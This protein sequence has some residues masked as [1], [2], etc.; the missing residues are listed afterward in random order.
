MRRST[1]QRR[2]AIAVLTAAGFVLAALTGVG[3]VHADHGTFPTSAGIYRIPYSDGM[4]LIVSGDHHNHGGT[5][6][7]GNNRIDMVADAPP[8]TVVA[9]A[10]GVVMAIVD[11]HG[12]S[13][14]NGDGLDVNG[15]SGQVLFDGVTIHSDAA[16]HSCQDQIEPDVDGDGV[17]D[18]DEDL[19]GSGTFN[20]IPNSTVIGLCQDYNNYIWIEHP[21]GEWSKYTHMDT[22]TITGAPGNLSV[23]DTVLVGQALGIESDIGA[24]TGRHLHHE[25]AV[26]TD[27]T[28]D[29]PFNDGSFRQLDT[30]PG[31]GNAN[32][33][34]SGTVGFF[35]GGFIQGTNL[36]PTVCDIPG[37][38]YADNVTSP[39]NNAFT[40]NPCTNT[41]P[42]ADA[43]GPYAVDEGSTVQLDGTGSSDPENA[44]LSFSWSPATRL[45][46]GTIATPTYDALD[47][48]V[49]EIDLTVSDV[50]GDVTPALALTDTDTAV[51]TVL[52]VAPTVTAVGDSID[53]A[54]TATVSATFTDPGT[55]DTHTATID[56]ADGTPAEPVT[57]GELEAGV[58]HVYGDNGDFDV[59]VTV[60]DDDGGSGDD[61]A[62]VSVANLDPTVTLDLSDQVSFPGGDYFVVEAGE[63]LAL[64]ADGTDPGSDDLT[65]T[66]GTGEVTTYFN[67]PADVPDPP[68][69]PLGTFPF[70]ASDAIDTVAPEPGV[71]TVS[72][73]L[74]DDDGGSDEVDAGAVVTGNADDA[75]SSGWWK[76]QYAGSGSPHIDA[77]TAAAYLEI[78]DAVSS[79]FSE[80]VAATTAAQAHDVLSP[81]G[82]RRARATADLLLAWLQFASGAVS[83]DASVPLPG[84][85]S[86]DYLDLMFEAEGVILDASA[87]NAE[88]KEIEHRLA[89]VVHAD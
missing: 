32:P 61:T 15:G 74:T 11:F 64:A 78:V 19:D 71:E 63:P 28:D 58:D 14:G 21:N 37:N 5:V 86:V 10:S 39:G 6:G 49:D 45:D 89:R 38:L 7:Q 9:A 65:F 51:V 69:S 70:A 52:N 66:W 2:A 36:V 76:H 23:G 79:V 41:A 22:G 4:G 57:I 59:V 48:T 82:D 43:G 67:D 27:A 12:D 87:S 8:A 55:L 56:W 84:G 73:V 34:G 31:G 24:A 46:D 54:G 85:D 88:L 77:D 16:E 20:R 68:L 47:D 81:T 3:P 72:V 80:Q 26:R 75:R 42:T 29:T 33:D 17:V 50:G 53:E 1:S 44:I 18:P 62:V 30:I 40:A 25:V 13:G 83:H 35:A 60:T